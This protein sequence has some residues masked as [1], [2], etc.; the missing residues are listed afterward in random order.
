M[1]L[2]SLDKKRPERW[3]VSLSHIRIQEGTF[4]QLRKRDLTGH[5][6]CWHLDLRL[7][8]IPNCEKKNAFCLGHPGF[9]IC[10]GSSNWLRHCHKRNYGR[11]IRAALDLLLVRIPT[12]LQE[13]VTNNRKT[14]AAL[15]DF[16]LSWTVDYNRRYNVQEKYF[17]FKATEP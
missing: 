11:W 12:A 3:P 4:L 6:I 1:G 8:S 17:H 7:P 9:D 14:F 13:I 16:S 2:V 10:Y 5:W 15:P